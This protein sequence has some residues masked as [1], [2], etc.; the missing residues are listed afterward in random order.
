MAKRKLT[1]ELAGTAP[2]TPVEPSYTALFASGDSVEAYVEDLCTPLYLAPFYEA[3]IAIAYEG[4]RL[5][6][7]A[8]DHGIF[9]LVLEDETRVSVVSRQLLTVTH[10]PLVEDAAVEV[11]VPLN[12]VDAD[13]DVLKANAIESQDGDAVG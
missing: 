10:T 3:R 11:V 5:T 8:R 2:E 7:M 12:A 6:S 1:E 9:R 4:K 13:G